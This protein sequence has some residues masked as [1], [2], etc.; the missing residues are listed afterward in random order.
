MNI[1]MHEILKYNCMLHCKVSI[2]GWLWTGRCLCA[3]R[4]GNPNILHLTRLWECLMDNLFIDLSAESLY[5]FAISLF[6][7]HAT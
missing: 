3:V 7:S 6:V 2:S 5:R 4:Y 1:H